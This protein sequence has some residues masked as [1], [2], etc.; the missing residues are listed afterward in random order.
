[1]RWLFLV[2]ILVA[3]S[4][5][6]YNS[7]YYFTGITLRVLVFIVS[8][9]CGKFEIMSHWGKDSCF[10]FCNR[11]PYILWSIIEQL[12]EVKLGG[13][14]VGRELSTLITC[15]GI[16]LSYP[17]STTLDCNVRWFFE[18]SHIKFAVFMLLYSCLRCYP[19]KIILRN[20][21]CHHPWS[22]D[23]IYH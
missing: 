6:P 18:V 3:F 21:F 14:E 16:I 5:S 19:W 2:N 15:C 8:T 1:M 11:W 10:H 20:L 7:C 4:L 12:F 17:L 13:V 23:F 9:N 22:W